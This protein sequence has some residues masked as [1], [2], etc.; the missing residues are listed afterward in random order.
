MLVIGGGS[1]QQLGGGKS[2]LKRVI[3]AN[4]KIA[5]GFD[6]FD[7]FMKVVFSTDG[8]GWNM[9]P[10]ADVRGI[11]C[12]ICGKKFTED[13]NDMAQQLRVDGAPD[14]WRFSHLP[15]WIGHLNLNER[16]LIQSAIEH[17]RRHLRPA[18][19]DKWYHIPYKIEAID[20]QYGGAWDTNWYEITFY[21]VIPIPVVLTFG[22]RKRVWNI[23]MNPTNL[24]GKIS[25]FTLPEKFLEGEETTKE[26]DKN[27]LL[28]HAWSRE[29]VNEYV[30][31][32]LGLLKHPEHPEDKN[33][34]LLHP[35]D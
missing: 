3:C 8:K 32:F 6:E 30:T 29:K 21:D 15:C 14:E 13:A 31:A 20:N 22:R 24:A 7:Q 12:V 2:P 16:D 11:P 25:E 9:S 34:D 1:I 26:F 28:I 33:W 10:A 19:K 17:A 35:K 18:N 23:E 27:S 5:F 4:E